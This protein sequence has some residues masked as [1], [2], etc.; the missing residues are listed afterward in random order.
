MIAKVSHTVNIIHNPDDTKMP[1]GNPFSH[2]QYAVYQ[3]PPNTGCVA[4][5]INNRLARKIISTVFQM[6]IR[7]YHGNYHMV[8]SLDEVYEIIE[9]KSS[10]RI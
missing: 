8:E 3:S 10:S 7:D 6:I 2:L 4:M 9:S 1:S 5:I